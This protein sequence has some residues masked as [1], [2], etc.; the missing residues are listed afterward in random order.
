MHGKWCLFILITMILFSLIWI[1]CADIRD[2]AHSI[3]AAAI[4]GAILVARVRWAIHVLHSVFVGHYHLPDLTQSAFDLA[5]V[6]KI[7]SHIFLED[8]F[9]SVRKV[10]L[11]SLL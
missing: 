3:C 8:S 9:E 1:G 11:P 5:F 2:G 10:R 6:Q 4:K 7:L